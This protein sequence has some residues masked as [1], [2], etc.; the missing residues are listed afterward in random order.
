M[1]FVT[2][3][4]GGL[5]SALTGGRIGGGLSNVITQ[6]LPSAQPQVPLVP[7]PPLIQDTAAAAQNAM[8]SLRRRRGRAASILSGLETATPNVATKTLL[9]T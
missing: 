5:A 7:P 8:D 4:L 2:D 9:G 1:S 3:F 6:L